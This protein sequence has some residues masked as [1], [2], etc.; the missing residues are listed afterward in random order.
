MFITKSSVCNILVFSLQTGFIIIGAVGM[1]VD[2]I[3][4]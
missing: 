3:V 2:F 1:K 4:L